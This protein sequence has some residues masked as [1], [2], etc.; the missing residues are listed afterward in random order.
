MIDPLADGQPPFWSGFF[1]SAD[2]GETW[3]FV[4]TISKHVN[5]VALA[6]IHDSMLYALM[7][8]DGAYA[9][10]Q[11]TSTDFDVTWTSIVDVTDLLGAVHRPMLYTYK[12]EPGRVYLTGRQFYSNN[13][14]R[15]FF[16]YSDDDGTSWSDPLIMQGSDLEDSSY[17]TMLKRSNGTY[18]L[19]TYEGTLEESDI[20]AY[21]IVGTP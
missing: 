1:E 8:Q 13:R 5:E 2:N 19:L 12:D 3:Q 17:T 15:T 16:R 10:R 4:E 6:Y 18:Y 7:R 14:E 9:T 11:A 20:V 21:I